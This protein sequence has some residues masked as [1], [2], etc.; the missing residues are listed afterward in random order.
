MSGFVCIA[1]ACQLGAYAGYTESTSPLTFV[2][3]CTL[4]DHATDLVSTDDGT[5]TH[6]LPFQFLYYNALGTNVWF[7][8]NGVV[9]FNGTPTT[10]YNLSAVCLPTT[11]L[12]MPVALPFWDDLQTRTNGVCTATTGTAP[13]RQ[14][15]ITWSDAYQRA[16]GSTTSHMN[17]SV[18][19]T[20]GT[21]TVDFVY[22][23]LT[24]DAYS[25][26][27]SSTIGVQGS[28]GAASVQHSCNSASLMS[29]TGVRYTPM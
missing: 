7:S 16:S 26:G 2:D 11:T 28:A 4:A 25:L 23:T 21:N 19:L 15:T 5:A 20:E 29:N 6:T 1:G 27:S 13:H 17:F 12:S 8:S 3:A 9:G 24:S 14:Y 22:G 18:V 10:N